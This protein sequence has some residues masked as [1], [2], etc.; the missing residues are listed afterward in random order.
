MEFPHFSFATKQLEQKLKCKMSANTRKTG[1]NTR[2]TSANLISVTNGYFWILLYY[3]I[4]GT[5]LNYLRSFCGYLYGT[6][7]EILDKEMGLLVFWDWG[8]SPQVKH[9]PVFGLSLLF[10]IESFVQG[11]PYRQSPLIVIEHIY[12]KLQPFS[13]ITQGQSRWLPVLLAQLRWST[14]LPY[15]QQIVLERPTRRWTSKLKLQSPV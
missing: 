2:K 8:S 3:D 10:F 15:W 12:L 5:L 13:R 6:E 11:S 9:S 4:M 7:L 14:E 1:A